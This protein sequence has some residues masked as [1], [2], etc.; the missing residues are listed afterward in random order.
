MRGRKDARRP[1]P[2]AGDF[3]EAGRLRPALRRRRPRPEG[4]R[5]GRWRPGDSLLPSPGAALAAHGAGRAVAFLHDHADVRFHE[6][7]HVHH[8]PGGS[9][10]G[11]RSAGARGGEGRSPGRSQPP[12]A[13]LHGSGSVPDRTFSGFSLFPVSGQGK[14]G[15]SEYG[16]HH[17]VVLSHENDNSA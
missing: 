7:G 12:A 11:A 16:G 15:S 13:R 3:R 17:L 4:G 14:R 8:L 10:T 2:P 9:R 6:L 1:R 5:S